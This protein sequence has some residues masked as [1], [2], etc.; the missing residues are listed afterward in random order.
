MLYICLFYF[1]LPSVPL[2]LF[3]RR[4]T[5]YLQVPVDDPHIMQILH[6]IQDL[7]DELAGIPLC[8]ETFLYDPVE[9]LTTR[10]TEIKR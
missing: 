7:V 1:L 10:N 6:S 8:V 5:R 4:E 3:A 2:K 9:Q